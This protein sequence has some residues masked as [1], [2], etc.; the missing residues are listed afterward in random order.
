MDAGDND[1]DVW[2]TFQNEVF[3][4]RSGILLSDYVFAVNFS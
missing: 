4:L 3:P 1:P 2:P